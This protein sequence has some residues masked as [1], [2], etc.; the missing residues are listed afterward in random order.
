MAIA[1]R[2]RPADIRWVVRGLSILACI[3]L[4][5]AASVTHLNLGIVTFRN[6]PPPLEVVESA[7]ALFRSPK[8]AAHVPSSLGRVFGGGANSGTLAALPVTP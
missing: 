7:V 5:Q 4:W 3:A 6:V 1:P 2:A 8:L